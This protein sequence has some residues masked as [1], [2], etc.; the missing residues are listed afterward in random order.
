M[1][2]IQRCPGTHNNEKCDEVRQKRAD[3]GIY[4]LEVQMGNFDLFIGDGRL[5]IEL[6]PG[7]NSCAYHGYQGQQVGLI[8]LDWRYQRLMQDLP[9]VRMDENAAEHIA[10]VYQA[11]PEQYAFDVA[12]A[13]AN[14]QHPDKDGCDRNRNKRADTKNTHRTGDARKFGHRCSG[15]GN[16]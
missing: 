9:P 4:P 16:E 14:H 2:D 6:H 13:A 15:I 1:I 3:I 5:L 7:G 11:Q 8:E 10:E 12:V